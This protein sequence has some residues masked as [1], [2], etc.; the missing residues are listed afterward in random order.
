MASKLA[1]L[2]VGNRVRGKQVFC[3]IGCGNLNRSD[4]G[5]GVCVAQRLATHFARQERSD[6]K[7]VDAGTGGME[8]MFQARGATSLI[9]VDASRSN[10]IAGSIFKVPGEV[11]ANAPEP[12]YTLHNFR[13]DH[14]I[15]AGRMIFKEDFPKDVTVYLIE[16]ED[17][18]FGL[19]LSESVSVAAEN[20]VSQILT[21]LGEERA[22]D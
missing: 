21:Q 4:D 6:V 17:L 11:L 13:W 2:N 22:H 12:A 20:V 5:V 3:I 8:V 15:Y 19:K 16:A 14:A 1:T 7:V 9:I 18:S 10:S